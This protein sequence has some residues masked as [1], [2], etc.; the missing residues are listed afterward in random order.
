[1]ICDFNEEAEGSQE[2]YGGGL[3]P[4]KKFKYFYNIVIFKILFKY[5]MPRIIF[6]PQK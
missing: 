6:N 1:M 4:P 5:Y 2:H 3:K